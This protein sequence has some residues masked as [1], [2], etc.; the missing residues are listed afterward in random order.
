MSKAR[1]RWCRI[2]NSRR[3]CQFFDI[4][5]N[6][7]KT[8]PVLVPVHCDK[9]ADWICRSRCGCG[10]CDMTTVFCDEHKVWSAQRD[11]EVLAAAPRKA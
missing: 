7:T 6:G 2:K 8:K 1:R 10:A 9:K 11:A 3:T 4:A 5:N